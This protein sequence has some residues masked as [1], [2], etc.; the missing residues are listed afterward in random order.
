VRDG[1]LDA[2]PVR[3]A[4][5]VLAGGRARR[6]GGRDKPMVAVGGVPMV[7]R[8]LAATQ[9]AGAASSVVVGPVRAGLPVGVPVV[10]EEP[11]G[12][13]PVAAA[14]AGLAALADHHDVVALL[15]GDLPWLTA[16]A[17]ERLVNALGPKDGAVFVDQDGRRQ[18]LCGV[19]RIGALRDAIRRM[20]DTNGGSMRRLTEG[21]DVVEVRWE[22]DRP[23]YF[24]CDTED[25]L[26]RVMG[27]A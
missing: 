5:V 3:L 1:H 20:D 2:V 9:A 26:R 14:A 15:A 24:D 4:A 6:F 16:E 23:P 8:V 12:G 13:G 25:D 19:W 7:Q 22:G 27:D 18:V 17:I 11:P 21:L 10:R